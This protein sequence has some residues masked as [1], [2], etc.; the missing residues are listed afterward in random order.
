M[1]RVSDD[2]P[3]AL[4]VGL[5]LAAIQAPLA[6][7]AADW[8][9]FRGPASNS[10][11]AASEGPADWDLD[12][13][14]AWKVVLPGRG[15]SSP[16]VV[17]D[18]IF[19]TASSGANQDR[20][21]VLCFD[22]ADGKRRW[23]RQFWATGRTITHPQSANAAPTPASDGKAVFAF[24][25]SNDLA[26]LDLDGNLLWYRG[27]ARDYPRIGNDAGM[28]SSPVVIDDVVIVQT[29]SL[30]GA[31]ATG[32]DARDGSTRWRDDRDKTSS[33][34]SPI[35][36]RYAPSGAPAVLVQSINRLDCLDSTSG[37]QLWSYPAA[38]DGISSAC[39]AG[40]LIFLPSQGITALRSTAGK[41]EPEIVWKSNQ[42]QPGAASPVVADG[43]L[44][45]INRSGVLVV[46]DCDT[47]DIVSRT[48][49]EG[50]FWSSP[51]VCGNHLLAFNHEDGTG[52]V[53]GLGPD[54]GS[55]RVVAKLVLGER[56]QASPAVADKAIYI[57]SD[58]HLW[59]L[60]AAA[61]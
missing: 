34:T 53:V 11:V 56:I 13:M 46:A 38:C 30:G 23:D 17:G 44:Y 7:R 49:L 58:H 14:M 50:S 6:A 24:F 55:T 61:R 36:F 59:K 16:I 12:K 40:G 20:L 31:L 5:L 9:Q 15:P 26:A 4:A 57:R 52:Q 42:L 1:S 19:V 33:W 35:S 28:A 43:K 41:P 32:I 3:L 48:R 2:R 8:A 29:E 54:A 37:K 21:H 45:L 60:A 51:L 25:S 18:R 47:G 10:A 22:A 39:T 27:L